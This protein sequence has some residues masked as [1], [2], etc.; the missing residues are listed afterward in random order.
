MNLLFAPLSYVVVLRGYNDRPRGHQGRS[1]GFGGYSGGY[2]GRSQGHHGGR[3]GG[4]GGK[5]AM[6]LSTTPNTILE[7]ELFGDQRAEV[8]KIIFY[9]GI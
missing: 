3:R 8:T 5:A 7:R 6:E 9:H 1:G 2:G 4:R